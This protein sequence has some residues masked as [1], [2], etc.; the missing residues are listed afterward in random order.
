M[1]YQEL[2]DHFGT[3]AAITRAFNER[4]YKLRQPSVAGWKK[5]GIP[6]PRQFQIEVITNGALRAERPQEVSA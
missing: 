1:T 3:Q 6:E 4:G 2:L 5:S